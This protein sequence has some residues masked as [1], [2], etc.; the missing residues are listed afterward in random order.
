MAFRAHSEHKYLGVCTQQLICQLGLESEFLDVL[1]NLP[2]RSAF[3][4]LGNTFR[5]GGGGGGGVETKKKSAVQ[6]VLEIKKKKL[7]VVPMPNAGQ[8]NP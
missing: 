8:P 3:S 2:S 7:Q 5:V 1:L 6:S 4:S